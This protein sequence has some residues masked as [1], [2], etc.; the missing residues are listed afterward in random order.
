MI[1]WDALIALSFILFLMLG[2]IGL[3]Y[4]DVKT[5]GSSTFEHLHFVAENAMDTV[6]KQGVLDEVGQYWASGNASAAGNLTRDSL[7]NLIP[8]QMGY[9]LEVVTDDGVSVIYDSGPTRPPEDAAS[10]KTKSSRMVSGYDTDKPR[11]GWAARAWLTLNKNWV[12]NMISNTSICCNGWE[13]LLMGYDPASSTGSVFYV[14]VP[15]HAVISSAALNLSWR[16]DIG[17]TTTTTTSTTTTTTSTTTTTLGCFTCPPYPDECDISQYGRWGRTSESS[18][19]YYMFIIPTGSQCDVTVTLDT[20]SS[21][22]LPYGVNWYDMYANWWGASSPSCDCAGDGRTTNGCTCQCQQPTDWPSN[23]VWDDC[24][25]WYQ[26]NGAQIRT[27]GPTTLGEGT[28]YLMISCFHPVGGGNLCTGEDYSVTISST[29]STPGSDCPNS[30]LEEQEED[31]TVDDVTEEADE[32]DDVAEEDEEDVTVDEAPEED[33]V[34]EEEPNVCTAKPTSIIYNTGCL[35]E[36]GLGNIDCGKVLYTPNIRLNQQDHTLGS[37][38]SGGWDVNIWQK[39]QPD[40]DDMSIGYDTPWDPPYYSNPYVH[41]SAEGGF[42]NSYFEF[43][44]DIPSTPADTISLDIMAM[45]EADCISQI[46][47][48]ED[49]AIIPVGI[50]S[51]GSTALCYFGGNWDIFWSKW[52]NCHIDID[53]TQYPG[54]VIQAG[55]NKFKVVFPIQQDPDCDMGSCSCLYNRP[56]TMFFDS[57]DIKYC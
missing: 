7:E 5:K 23:W 10:D 45:P 53:T 28:Y 49:S 1:T 56:C 48:Y 17:A 21:A 18:Y 44:V 37:S 8:K 57:I 26:P 35:P 15:S 34:V 38:Y 6:N 9:R 31:D 3:Q 54:N 36:N 40:E 20:G 41:H 14:T 42:E 55:T 39:G 50:C 51:V 27:C 22:E 11:S 32:V 12:G 46:L 43:T 24:I 19:A 4:T 25:T 13:S 29:P 30:D 33:D 52:D 2:F 47:V 16:E